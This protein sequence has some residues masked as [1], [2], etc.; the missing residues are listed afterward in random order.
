M[1]AP[2]SAQALMPF[3]PA[4]DYLQSQAFY[5]ALGFTA[6]YS[7]DSITLFKLDTCRFYLQNF[8]AK[9]LAQNLML[10][11]LV[12][13]LEAW[14]AHLQTLDLSAFE[15]ARFDPPAVRPWGQR[16]INLFDPGGVLWYVAQA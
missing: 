14:W 15:G 9:P 2:L 8:Y 4:K 6:D 3:V 7:D 13:D 5:T 16:V 12:D 10:Q 11:L 1:S